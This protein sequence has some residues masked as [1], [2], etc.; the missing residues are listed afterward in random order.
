[1]AKVVT[2]EVICLPP[3]LASQSPCY[4]M[5][6]NT[7]A[8]VSSNQK[9]ESKPIVACSHVFYR[10]L[11]HYFDWYMG[12]CVSFEIGLRDNLSVRSTTFIWS[13]CT[14]AVH[15]WYFA[16]EDRRLLCPTFSEGTKNF[17]A[18]DLRT[19]TKA[20]LKMTNDLLNVITIKTQS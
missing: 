17:S 13:I 16:S 12:L 4:T 11:C 2:W 20:L 15:R 8:A 6:Q 14:K 10:T 19:K 9:I 7:R 3:Y 18:S 1:M 5:A